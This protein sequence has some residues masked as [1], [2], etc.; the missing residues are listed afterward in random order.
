[1][2]Q[3]GEHR[4]DRD[5][6]QTSQ[7]YYTEEQAPNKSTVPDRGTGTKRVNSTTQ[8]NRHQTS[9]QYQRQ[10]PKE[11]QRGST[12]ETGT[13]QVNST[14]AQSP[15][16]SSERAQRRQAPKSTVPTFTW[17]T[18]GHPARE[19]RGHGHQTS[20]HYQLTPPRGIQRE[21]TEDTGTKQVDTTN[22][23]PQGAS[24]ERA[25]RTRA[26]NKSTVLTSHPQGGSSERAQRTRATNKS[27]L[28]RGV[29][30]GGTEETG[31]KQVDTTKRLSLIHI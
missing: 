24:S 20:R 3:P 21:S 19:Y 10:T 30:Q 29:Q 28:P 9:R 6:H 31:T 14:N 15:R 2:I 17:H 12:E 27:T 26:P 8:R 1:M 25:Q 13:E 4:G 7:Q 5:R 22:S 11:I 16:K 23:H 18:K